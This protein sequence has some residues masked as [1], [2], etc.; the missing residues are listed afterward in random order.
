[1]PHLFTRN[2][3]DVNAENLTKHNYINCVYFLYNNDTL[4]YIGRTFILSQRIKQHLH[5]KVFNRFNYIQCCDYEAYLLEYE[6]IETFKPMYNKRITII[7]NELQRYYSEIYDL[8]L[9]YMRNPENLK[10]QDATEKTSAK[11]HITTQTVYNAVCYIRSNGKK[12]VDQ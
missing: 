2:T 10:P 12:G 9:K 8:R 1:M 6:M 4:V 11:L 7:G 5:D 3:M